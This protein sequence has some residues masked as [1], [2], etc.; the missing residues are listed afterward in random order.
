ME[1]CHIP[2]NN[3]ESNSSKSTLKCML[4]VTIDIFRFQLGSLFLD[5]LQTWRL[6][7]KKKK[8]GSREIV[9]IF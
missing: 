2:G 3:L 6:F 1:N 7:I 9:C 4:K 5:K 8:K